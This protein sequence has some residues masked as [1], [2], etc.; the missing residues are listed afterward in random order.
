MFTYHQII[1]V[2]VSSLASLI[3]L[4]SKFQLFRLFSIRVYLILD[5]V[6]PNFATP[7]ERKI[8]NRSMFRALFDLESDPDPHPNKNL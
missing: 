1:H 3:H 2:P 5:E 4:Y 8:G 7:G 6:L